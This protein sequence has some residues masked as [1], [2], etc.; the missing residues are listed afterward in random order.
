MRRRPGYG[1]VVS[2]IALFVALGGGALAATHL[3]ANSVGTKQL[4]NN[5]VT[6]AKVKDGSLAARDFGAGQLPQGPRGEQGPPG[7][8]GETG[9]PGTARA[10]AYVL[11]GKTPSL[12]PQRSRGFA[13]VSHAATGTYC[14]AAS[15]GIDVSAGAPAV[16][17]VFNN[18]ILEP[19]FAMP[20]PNLDCPDSEL[21]IVTYLPGKPITLTDG[22]DF[23]VVLP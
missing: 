18:G 19:E 1:D 22:L 16:T 20:S 14:L 12:D 10:Y 21:E 3:G 17:P 6:G 4:K 9:P 7:Q 8:P 23:T 15:S 13:S 2:T 5:A 11:G